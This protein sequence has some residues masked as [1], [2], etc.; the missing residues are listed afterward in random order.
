M[1]REP[2][3]IVIQGGDDYRSP[4]RSSMGCF[5]CMGALVKWS[6]IAF[7][8]SMLI[9]LVA[10]IRSAATRAPSSSPP[11]AASAPIPA[12]I[13]PKMLVDLPENVRALPVTT[14]Q[15]IFQEL[16]WA[17]M[18]ASK[19]AESEYPFSGMPTDPDEASAY[20]A[21]RKGVYDSR[22][23]ENWY[24]VGD[25]RGLDTPALVAIDNEGTVN[26][27]PVRDEQ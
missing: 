15:A 3:V 2:T 10:A 8:L 20:L 1:G 22:K 4:P 11:S 27:W 24:A 19:A 21:R 12:P 6:L 14:R 13:S 26:R 16:H 23:R 17:G 25:Q 5:G 9:G 18:R 7:G